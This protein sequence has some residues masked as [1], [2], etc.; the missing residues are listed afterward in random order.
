MK[1]GRFLEPA[2]NHFVLDAFDRPSF[3]AFVRFVVPYPGIW[4]ALD[5][6]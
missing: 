5:H 4:L 3:V 6:C 1:R 2:P